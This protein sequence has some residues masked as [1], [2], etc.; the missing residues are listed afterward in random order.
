MAKYYLLFSLVVSVVI[1]SGC[2]DVK[3][4]EPLVDFNDSYQTQRPSPVG[5]S[6]Q[7]EPAENS[8]EFQ[9]LKHQLNEC[10]SELGKKTHKCDEL[11]EELNRCEDQIDRLE[12]KIED[13]EDRN[14]DLRERLD[15]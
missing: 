4:D 8:A 10:Q 15:D 2:V 1:S 9:H 13:L 5:E 11:K 6:G 3:V 14:E 12:D 7:G